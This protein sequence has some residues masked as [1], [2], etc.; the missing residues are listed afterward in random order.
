MK[1]LLFALVVTG[2]MVFVQSCDKDD[3]SNCEGSRKGTIESPYGLDSCV[4]VIKFS[5][6]TY[7]TPINLF[8]FERNAYVGQRVHI[9]YDTTPI[10]YPCAIGPRVLIRCFD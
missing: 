9:T 4:Y 6:G 8:D 3:D 2:M 7:V 1:K 10:L 5:D